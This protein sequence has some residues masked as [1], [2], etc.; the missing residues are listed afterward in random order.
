MIS[1]IVTIILA[2]SPFLL[3]QSDFKILNSNQNSIIFEFTPKYIDTSLTKINGQEYRKADFAYG[4]TDES[5]SWGTPAVQERKLVIGVPSEF[6]NS[7][8]VLSSSYKQIDGSIIPVPKY[9]KE[10]FLDGMKYEIAPD[11]YNYEDFPELASFGDYGIARGLGTQDIR[12]FPVKFDV[13]TNTIRLYSKIVFQIDYGNGQFSGR[14]AEDELLKFSIINFD[15]AQYWVKEQ[16]KLSKIDGSVLATGQW[17][18]FEAQAEGI[19]K[20]DRAR[21][22]S[23]G[24]NVSSVD[25]RTIKIYNNDGKALSEMVTAPRPDDLIE[26]AIIVSGENDGS[27][28]QSDYILFYGRGSQFRDIHPVTKTIQRFNNPFS[29]KNYYWVTAGGE[30]GK[31]IQSKSS[32]NTN[33]DYTQSTTIAFTDQ[34]VDKINLAKSGRQFMGDDFSQNIPSRTYINKLD[35]RNS[36]YPINY[37]FRFINASQ[38]AFI[39]SVAEN[40]TNIFSGSLAGYSGELYTVGKP[41]NRTGV[42]N[43]ALPDNRSVL[44]FTLSST[45]VTSVGYLDYFEIT[46]EKDLK[47]VE[48][49]LIFFSK[50]SSAIVEYYLNGFPSSEIRVF[51]VTDFANIQIVDPKSGWPSGGDFRFQASENADSLRKYVAVGNGSY[52]TPSNPTA[53]ANS[54]IRGILDGAKFIIISHKKFLDAANR[55]KSYRENQARVPISTIVVD[56]EEIFNEFSCGIRDISAIRDFIKYA[57][58]NWQIKPEFFM[59]MGKGTYDYKNVESFGDNYI[60]TWQTEESLKLIWGADSYCSDDFFARVDEED[61]KPDIAFGRLTVRNLDEANTYINKIVYYENNSERGNWR[62]LITLVADDGY[63][64]TGYEGSEH[65]APSERLA[66]LIIP[67]SFDLKKIYAA[68]YPVVITGNGRRKPT[69]NAD[70]IKTMNQGTL[71]INYIGHGNPELWA[72][73]YIFERSVSLPQLNNDKYFF[74]CA[75][76]CDFGYYDIPNFQSGAEELLFLK[77]AG[78][79]A[80]FN[81][82]RLVFSGQNHA[83]NYT[84]MGYLLDLPRDTLNLN[85]PIGYSVFKTKI[86]WNSV[87]SQKF[88]LLGDPTIRLNVPQYVGSIDSINGQLLNADIQIKA[89]SST[90]IAGSILRP[91]STKWND[92]NGEGLLTIYDSERTKL[93]EEIGNYPMIIQ[94]GVI[95]RGRVSVNNGEFTAEFVVPKDISYENK[96][97]KII[98][99]FFDL[100][101]DGLAFTNKIIVGGTDTTAVNDGN[102]P[103]IEIFFDDASYA[104]SYLV[105]P[106]PNLIVKL[107]DETGLNT[108]GTG[109]GHKLE[110]ILNED[111]GSPIDFTEFFVGEL[112]AGG[113]KGDINYKFNKMNDGDYTIEVKAWDVYNNFSNEESFFTVVNSNDLV[114]RDVYNYP[115]PFNSN[116]TFTFQHN[117]TQPVDVKI[118]IYTIAGRKVQQLEEKNINEKFVKIYWDGT[119]GDGDQMANGTYLYKLIVST[120]NGEFTQSVIGKMAIIK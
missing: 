43:G 70:I 112:D 23:F 57:Y 82:C 20:I 99:Y 41:Y 22:E 7:I 3:P 2:F 114:I 93:I 91:D 78:S 50:D 89:L 60:P 29:D 95:F 100:E 75:A 102:G 73:E 119:D 1:K 5:I 96:N 68:N 25:P 76:T 26:N 106:E 34:E 108:T 53:I 48:N 38:S 14:K 110:G 33:A 103:E 4:Y 94:G 107:F 44:K 104:N 92:F 83:L 84:L 111:Q 24:F 51:D 45:S 31:R 105:G 52:L 58:D 30:N 42:F 59:F 62:N 113:K 90:K 81:S 72:H 64:S 86:E 21:L 19:Y 36:S 46:Y 101:S 85:V 13:N 74:L 54:N 47:P 80:T 118:N 17:V 88:H 16:N 10:N 37:N 71:L 11:Y 67:P 32:L 9:E 117:L 39:L 79:I 49:K 109:V 120:T 87:N 28:D 63:T 56:V 6:G 69:V 8:K 35:N 97:G 65:T 12:L 15:A 66:N 55:L 116:T 98:F 61:A 40:S 27:F 115:N 77:D 18:R